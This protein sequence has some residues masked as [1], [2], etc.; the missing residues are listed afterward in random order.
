MVVVAP[1]H[2]PPVYIMSTLHTKDYKFCWLEENRM[3]TRNLRSIFARVRYN[4][5]GMLA[6][7]AGDGWAGVLNFKFLFTSVGVFCNTQLFSTLDFL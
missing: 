3:F 1:T 5:A 2:V 6:R 4:P 7:R